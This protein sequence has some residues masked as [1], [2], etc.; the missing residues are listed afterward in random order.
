M[1]WLNIFSNDLLL[2]IAQFLVI[3][4]GSMLMGILLSNLYWG[5]LRRKIASLTE[6]LEEEKLKTEQLQKQVVES[7]FLKSELEKEVADLHSKN[8]SQSKT[9][10]EQNQ[11]I[12]GRESEQKNLRTTIDEL[13]ANVE[14]YKQRMQVV[15]EELEKAK[16]LAPAPAQPKKKKAPALVRA[17][18]EQV[19]KLLGRQVTENDFTLIL[20]IGPKTASLLHSHG[21][22]SWDELGSTAIGV[23]RDLLTNAGGV[24]RAQDPTH[25]ARQARM[26]SRGEW[27]KLR[28][29]Q[30]S[31]RQ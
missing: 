17:N 7:G 23:L 3:V 20:G 15:E 29:F 5:G 31:L 6:S 10:F 24:F 13:N 12:Y 18:Y 16:T 11:F 26:A 9:I 22:R 28:V 8:D 14:H 2:L 27:R 30:E 4:V 21:I 25:W 1:F 19:S